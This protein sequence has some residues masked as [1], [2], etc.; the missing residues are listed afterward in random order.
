MKKLWF[1]AAAVTV[2]AAAAPAL[3]FQPRSFVSA[4][5]APSGEGAAK[6]SDLTT[7]PRMGTW[8]FDLAGRDTS[9]SPGHDFFAYANGHYLEQLE[10]PSDRSRYGAFDALNELSVNRMRAVVEA[11]ANDS[12]AVGDRAKIGDF[13]KSFMDEARVEAL[14]AKPLAADLAEV[15]AAKTRADLARLMG[16]SQAA[17]G[18]SF[19][20]AYISDDAK[21]PEHYAVYLFQAGLGM[22]DRDYYLQERFAPQ[23]E[24]YEAYVAR[25]LSLA[26]WSEPEAHAK[27]IVAMETKIAE[28]S[29]TRAER[30]DDDKTYNPFETAKLAEY[31]P[32]FDWA[33]FMEG[34]GLAKVDRVIVA[35]NTAFPKIAAVFA[36]TPVDTLKAWAAFTLADNAAP[37]LSK[38]F[39]EAHFDFRNRTLS[40]QPEQRPRWKRGVSLVDNQ[41]GEALGKVY[42]EAYFPP[43][44]KAKMEALVGDI[45]TAMHGRIEKLTWMSPTTKAKALEKLSKFNVKIGYPDKWRDYS[46]LAVAADDLYGNVE[47]AVAFDW[48]YRVGRL[49]GPVDDSEWG[50]TPPTINAYYSSTKNEIVFPAAILQPPFFDP[51]GDPAI[52]YGGIGGVIGH[53][54]THGFDDQGRKSDGD[55]RLTDWWT[56]EDAAKFQ[57][58]AAKLG[59]QYAA[60]EVLPGAHINGDLTMGENIADLGGLL[61][62]LDAY[63]LS[64]GGKPAPVIDGL[65]GDQRVFLGWAQVWRG[66]YREDAIKQQLVSD[67]HSPPKYRVNVPITNI[68]AWYAAFGVK[69]DDAMYVKPEDRV[70]IW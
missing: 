22:P 57:A 51:D 11:A 26:G 6:I 44:S 15:S 67:P 8:G 25:L 30:R 24:K 21:D 18:G 69:P 52:N 20:G 1:A 38:D 66:K 43:E 39:D 36:E 5:D 28:V 16:K 13:Y 14:G 48:N 9:V 61:L 65:T 49:G 56:P 17:F 58:Q 34:A 60:V 35:E 63:H 42:V 59:A 53:E 64:L 7:A 45:K 23:K 3:A 54:I 55:G 29:W 33:A 41:I 47:R 70:R 2:L 10:I 4:A 32:G 50:M 46:G 12:G 19:F 68:D 27:A 40:G 62:A 31:A 37:Y